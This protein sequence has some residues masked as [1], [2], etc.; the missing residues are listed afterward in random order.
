M[1]K[2]ILVAVPI[3]IVVALAVFLQGWVLAVFAAALACACQFEIVRAMDANGKPVVKWVSYLFA[4]IAAVLFLLSVQ[5]EQA[6]YNS[7]RWLTPE[8]VI[9]LF[10][11]MTMA[12]FIAAMLSKRHEAKSVINTGFTMIYPQLFMILFYWIILNSGGGV[13]QSDSYWRTLILLLMIFLPAM[14]SDTA[15]YFIGKTFGKTKL[16]PAISPKKTVAGS[17]AGVFGGV[18]AA[19]LIFLVFDNMILINGHFVEMAPVANYIAA[20]AVLAVV[21][22]FGDLAASYLKRALSIKDFGKLLPGH[23]GIVDRMDSILFCIPAVYMMTNILWV[24]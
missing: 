7:L 6:G 4:G 21:S 23:G 17:V 3:V 18:L 14:F 11:A 16:C 2:R 24:F 1:G 13:T 8:V 20:G 15:A 10:A 12:A 5:A 9:A 19:L 22:Q